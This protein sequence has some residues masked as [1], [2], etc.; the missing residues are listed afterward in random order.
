MAHPEV[1]F[2][3]SFSTMFEILKVIGTAMLMVIGIPVFL[4][5]ISVLT[6]LFARLGENDEDQV[7]LRFKKGVIYNDQKLH[8]ANHAVESKRD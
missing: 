3:G 4:I 2:S 7:H 8:K 6:L 5:T 1:L